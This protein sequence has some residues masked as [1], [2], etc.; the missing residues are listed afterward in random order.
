MYKVNNYILKLPSF[1]LKTFS[2]IF[3]I[4]KLKKTV[5]NK[6]KVTNFTLKLFP[7]LICVVFLFPVLKENISSFCVVLL[8][9]NLVV[10][11]ITAKDYS[12]IRFKELLLTI[13]FW[14]ILIASF[15]SSDLKISQIHVQHA[16]FFLVVPVI[17]LLIPKEFFSLKKINIYLSVL[18]NT[19]L[20]IT[21]IYFASYF[22]NISFWK[23]KLG[24]Y[25]YSDFREY[26]YYEFKAFK[27]HPTYFSFILILCTAYSYELVLKQKK[28]LHLVYVVV[29]IIIVFLLLTKLSIVL[30]V[31]WLLFMTFFRSSLTLNYQITLCLSVVIL[32]ALLIVYVPGI[33]I[34]FVETINSF[35]IKPKDLAYDSTNVRKA[36]LDC[37][38]KLAKE[39]WF[40]GIGYENLQNGL[41]NCYKSSYNS[42]FYINH[43]YMTHNY[44]LYTLISS[45]IL[46]FGFYLVY[47]INLI[48]ISFKKNMF[49]FNLLIINTIIICFTEDYFYRQHGVLYFNLLLMIFIRSNKSKRSSSIEGGI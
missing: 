12:L 31:C 4:K 28:Y 48:K 35:N 25:E 38:L 2:F 16:L 15:F 22:Q 33:S 24:Y 19:C 40:S 36:I 10:Y 44:Y 20:L 5:L 27:I 6:I 49:L 18:N 45:G 13:P 46:G 11:K 32:L 26:I 9:L 41:N 7:I 17:F 42:S 39:N 34:R 47:L 37:D 30:L 3:A 14:I 1:H 23:F 29:F 43:D 8:G 21:L